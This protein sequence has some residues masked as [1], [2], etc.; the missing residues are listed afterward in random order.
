V[1]DALINSILSALLLITI[2]FFKRVYETSR[3]L[4]WS[5]TYRLAFAL[6]VVAA[7]TS[8]VITLMSWATVL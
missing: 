2:V 6:L 8:A 4:R 3:D 5:H 7:F 1:L